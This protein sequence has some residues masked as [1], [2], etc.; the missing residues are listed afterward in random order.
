VQHRA[1]SQ[2]GFDL[3]AEIENGRGDRVGVGQVRPHAV[4]IRVEIAC[5]V[6]A[7]HG[8][9]VFKLANQKVGGQIG[10][11]ESRAARSNSTAI[12]PQ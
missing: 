4:Q 8:A 1:W 7:E 12:E 6:Q 11:T 10:D 2:Y 3:F 5:S 9:S